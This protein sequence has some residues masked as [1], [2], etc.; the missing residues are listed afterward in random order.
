MSHQGITPA[1]GQRFGTYARIW[2]AAAPLTTIL[3]ANRLPP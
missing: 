1:A 3:V 2:A